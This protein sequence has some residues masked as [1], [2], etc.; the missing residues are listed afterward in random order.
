MISYRHTYHQL[1]QLPKSVLQLQADFSELHNIERFVSQI[2]T[3]CESVKAVIHNASAWQ[4]EQNADI[5]QDSRLFQAL[6]RIHAE[7]PY[8]LNRQLFPL[9]HVS[10]Q[11]RQATSD[12]IHITRFCRLQRK[13]KTSCL[14]RQQSRIRKFDPLF[15][16][17]ICTA[18]KSEQHCPFFNYV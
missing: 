2:K 13:P 1:T 9:L 8:L 7:L 11:Q 12:I 18:S 6:I 16:S 5:L 10:A 14:C 15:C 17:T 4:A 3:H